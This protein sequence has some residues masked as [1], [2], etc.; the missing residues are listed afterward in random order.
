MNWFKELFGF[1]D[2]M[3]T[4]IHGL[5]Y[6][7]SSTPMP[8]VKPCK[9]EK[10]ISEPVHVIVKNMLDHPS[11]W[12]VKF[13]TIFSLHTSETNYT[14]KDTKTG[15]EFRA[16]YNYY[17]GCSPA[18]SVDVLVSWITSD[19]ANLLEDTLKEV[20]QIKKARRTRLANYKKNQERNRLLE[21]Y[22]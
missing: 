11:R 5:P 2:K 22:K 17:H 19:E 14:I 21:I 13:K 15:E 7:K 4:D 1:G 10:N 6:V 8:E 20:Y 3:E 12:K 16:K 9:P 18:S